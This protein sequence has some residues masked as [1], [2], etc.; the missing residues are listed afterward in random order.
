M[1]TITKKVETTEPHLTV[2]LNE[3]LDSGFDPLSHGAVC[4]I[5]KNSEGKYLIM[6]RSL[7]D[8]DGPGE[9]DIVGG[10]CDEPNVQLSAIR[11]LSEEAGIDVDHLPYFG[12][13][14]YVCPW[15]GENK[16]CFIFHLNVEDQEP[17]I[18]H[19]HETMA[20]VDHTEFGNYGFYKQSV[21]DS[22]K[23]H[24]E[25]FESK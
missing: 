5:V 23:S 7:V 2:R 22:L 12:E 9:Y 24:A 13:H 6:Q 10:S 17:T 14:S 4:V 3:L 21:I 16:I 1:N 20:W 25:G 18:S 15:N 8:L 19:E 11:E